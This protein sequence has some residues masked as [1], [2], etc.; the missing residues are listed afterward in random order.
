MTFL[1]K[2]LFYR[3]NAIFFM[4]TKNISVELQKNENLPLKETYI[5][6]FNSKKKIKIEQKYIKQ[7][8]NQKITLNIHECKRLINLLHHYLLDDDFKPYKDKVLKFKNNSKMT[9]D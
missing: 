5:V 3:R 6:V 7:D 2:S 9:N 8:A 4:I 1:K